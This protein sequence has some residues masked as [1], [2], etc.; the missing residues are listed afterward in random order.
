MSQQQLLDRQDAVLIEPPVL[1]SIGPLPPEQLFFGAAPSEQAFCGPMGLLQGPSF[2][3]GELKRIRELI[4]ARLVEN[5]HQLSAQAGAD[6]ESI[7]L[8][9]YHLVSDRHDHSKL[10]S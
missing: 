10:L 6:V 7:E 5:A 8:D 4:K 9:Q 1:R 3:D 2:T